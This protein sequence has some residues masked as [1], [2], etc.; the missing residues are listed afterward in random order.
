MK[1]T[2]SRGDGEAGNGARERE[3]SKADRGRTG[4]ERDGDLKSEQHEFVCSVLLQ[5]FPLLV[6]RCPVSCALDRSRGPRSDMASP[7][8]L[9]WSAPRRMA[10]SGRV[11]RGAGRAS[12]HTL[13][14]CSLP[15]PPGRAIPPVSIRPC[16]SD[17][18][19]GSI[20]RAAV[21]ACKKRR[22]RD[23]WQWLRAETHPESSSLS[24]RCFF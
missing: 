18:G 1:R 6:A 4:V 19:V 20:L 14:W 5:C 2:G 24:A 11:E 16:G 10:E 13:R 8:S 9:R 21:H 3:M 17:R 7:P 12:E 23:E 15:S 22:R